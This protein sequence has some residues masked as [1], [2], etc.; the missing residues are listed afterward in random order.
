MFQR[1]C[2]LPVFP[3]QALEKSGQDLLGRDIFVDL[4]QERGNKT[5]TPRSGGGNFR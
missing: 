3:P 5:F 4:A 2:F 1:L